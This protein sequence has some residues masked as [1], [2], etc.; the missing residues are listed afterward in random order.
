MGKNE[1]TVAVSD[2]LGHFKAVFFPKFCYFGVIFWKLDASKKRHF[3]DSKIRSK[4]TL[5]IY[6]KKLE[7]TKWA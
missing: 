5:K 2:C 4:T 1:Q 7:M 6:F 3:P